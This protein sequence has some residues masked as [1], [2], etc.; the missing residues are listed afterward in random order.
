MY[1]V[2]ASGDIAVFSSMEDLETLEL[3]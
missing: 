2:K 3:I 1:G